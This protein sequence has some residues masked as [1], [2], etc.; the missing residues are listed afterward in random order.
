MKV[1][2]YYI[3]RLIKYVSIRILSQSPPLGDAQLFSGE[4]IVYNN[5]I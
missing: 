3:T 1:M 4:A 5:I 2:L